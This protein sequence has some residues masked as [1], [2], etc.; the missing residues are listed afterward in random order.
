MLRPP[1]FSSII[2]TLT[3]LYATALT[4]LVSSGSARDAWLGQL[5]P[6]LGV[7][8]LMHEPHTLANNDS[9]IVITRT[10]TVTATTTITSVQTVAPAT[11]GPAYCKECGDEDS[12]CKEYGR[13]NLE[14]SRGYEGTNARLKRVLQ[15]AAS[16]KPINIGVLGGSVT[17]GHGAAEGQRWTDLFF[18]WWNATYPGV[19]GSTFSHEHNVF[20]NG[21]VPATGSEYFSVCALEHID[22]EVDLVI[23]EM[24]INDLRGEDS[25]KSYEWLMRLLLSQ[26]NRPAIISTHVFSVHFEY[27]ATG[28]DNHLAVAQYYDIPYINLR[29]VLLNNV[30]EHENLI[31][32]FFRPQEP[33]PTDLPVDTRHM[34]RVGHKMLADLLIA[35]I[36]RQICRLAADAEYPA[37]PFASKDNLLPTLDTMEQVP[38]AVA[39]ILTR[40]LAYLFITEL[41]SSTNTSPRSQD[42]ELQLTEILGGKK[43]QRRLETLRNG[44]PLL[45]GAGVAVDKVVVVVVVAFAVVVK[46][47]VTAKRQMTHPTRRARS[48]KFE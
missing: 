48:T 41:A 27:L 31:P 10:Q 40:N 28:G 16:G 8:E 30:L 47:V 37:A 35:Y 11:P 4:L 12:L 19:N 45:E 46:G 32:E 39:D 44:S 43:K 36:Q 7:N 9:A 25:A 5:L 20:V 26:T 24:A 21:A 2:A 6:S 14:R 15:K 3:V 17:H 18:G 34:N 33:F 13:H 23:I 22:E 1:R 38:R 29:H 42:F